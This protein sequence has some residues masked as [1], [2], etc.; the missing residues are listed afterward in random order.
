MEFG[1]LDKW[2][3]LWELAMPTTTI[4]SAMPYM[5]A[6]QEGKFTTRGAGREGAPR[7]A[8]LLSHHDESE[9]PSW[10]PL[11]REPLCSSQTDC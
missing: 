5:K 7:I 6:I 2:I 1:Y 10:F 4:I 8:P 9:P 3:L 11:F